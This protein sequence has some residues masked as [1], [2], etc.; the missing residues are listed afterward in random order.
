MGQDFM[1]EKSLQEKQIINYIKVIEMKVATV[2]QCISLCKKMLRKLVHS[3][4]EQRE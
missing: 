2:E 3:Q 1:Y 4:L